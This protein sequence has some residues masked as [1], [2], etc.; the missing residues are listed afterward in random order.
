M[1]T[2]TRKTEAKLKKERLDQNW[3]RY[4][5]VGLLFRDKKKNIADTFNSHTKQHNLCFTLICCTKLQT[6]ATFRLRGMIHSRCIM[7]NKLR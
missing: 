1:K 7:W 3:R 6:A 4:Q 2:A 5:T